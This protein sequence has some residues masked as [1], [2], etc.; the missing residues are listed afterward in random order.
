MMRMLL[1]ILLLTLLLLLV[2]MME[3]MELVH[4]AWFVK[5]VCASDGHN[6]GL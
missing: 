3:L 4:D 2:R 1:T 6:G 5:R